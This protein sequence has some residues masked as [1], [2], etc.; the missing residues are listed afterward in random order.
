MQRAL[1]AAENA[2]I[3]RQ[4]QGGTLAPPPATYRRDPDIPP[5]VVPII[6]IVFG[7]VLVMVIVTPIVRGILRLIERRQDKD[8]VHGPTVAAQLQELQQSID[9]LTIDMERISEAQRFQSKLMA[10]REKISLPVGN[11]GA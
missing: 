10:E 5:E 11:G 4:S 7:S 3:A 8:L 1:Q 9:A 2:A 6:G